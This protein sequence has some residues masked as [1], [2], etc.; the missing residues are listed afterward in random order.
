MATLR[1][2]RIE[3]RL[4]TVQLAHKSEVSLSSINRME[5][6]KSA[7]KRL[8]ATRVLHTLSQELGRPLT[9]DEV[10]GLRLVD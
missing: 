1:D 10:E 8:I 4:T 3:A 7:V 9:I 2:L 6:G 5:Q